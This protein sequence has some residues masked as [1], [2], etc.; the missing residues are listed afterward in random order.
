MISAVSC[1]NDDSF[2]FSSVS[3]LS[4]LNDE[5]LTTRHK[6]QANNEIFGSVMHD[7]KHS[8]SELRDLKRRRGATFASAAGNSMSQLGSVASVTDG[9]RTPLQ[10]PLVGALS[11]IRAEINKM[12]SRSR[13]ISAG[14]NKPGPLY[15]PGRSMNSSPSREM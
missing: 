1:L 9:G 6:T 4:E 15:S 7:I 10:T 2:A 5:V 8:L 14:N 12:A 13:G 11:S 3:H